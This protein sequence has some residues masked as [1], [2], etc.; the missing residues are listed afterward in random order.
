MTDAVPI[1]ATVLGPDSTATRAIS[2][3]PALAEAVTLCDRRDLQ[4]Y[5][6]LPR[7]DTSPCAS[8]DGPLGVPA[9]I[10]RY[11]KPTWMQSPIRQ[12]IAS[13]VHEYV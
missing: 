2:A 4:G 11:T 3:L 5:P 1:L 12:R 10:Q 13:Y 6:V 9:L 7:I 8:A